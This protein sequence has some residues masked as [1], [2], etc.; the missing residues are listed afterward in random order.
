MSHETAMIAPGNV[1]ENSMALVASVSAAAIKE[2]V[3]LKASKGIEPL[4][5]HS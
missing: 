2:A 4:A 5:L 1:F 3:A